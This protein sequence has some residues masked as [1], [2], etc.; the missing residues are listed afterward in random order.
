MPA[1]GTISRMCVDVG[2]GNPWNKDFPLTN[3]RGFPVD[4]RLGFS[5]QVNKAFRTWGMN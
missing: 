5:S 4:S 3:T 1:D 2:G